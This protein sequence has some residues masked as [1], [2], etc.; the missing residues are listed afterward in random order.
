MYDDPAPPELLRERPMDAR[1][2]DALIARAFG[3][4]RFAKSAERLREGNRPN[5]DLSF[6]AWAGG[7]AVGC[8]RL[9]PVTV[10]TV[11]ALLLG[12]FAVD[13]VH[14]RQGLGATLINRACEAAAEAGHALI[15]LVGDAGYFGPLGFSAAPGVVMP[16]P[17]DRRRVLARALQPGGITDL[18]GAVVS[19]PGA[20]R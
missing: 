20:A 10:G 6:V 8:V 19:K 5:L 14:R 18:A 16:G 13:S 17:V 1:L 2:V 7:E 4:G 3:P 12:P 11:P 15:V 9:W